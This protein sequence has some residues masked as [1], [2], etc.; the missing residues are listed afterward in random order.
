MIV[1]DPLLILVLWVAIGLVVAMAIGRASDLGERSAKE[2][3][4][5]TRPGRDTALKTPRQ[6]RTNAKR[7]AGSG[8]TNAAGTDQRESQ[9]KH[10]KRA[11]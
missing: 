11:A 7:L 8:N 2:G 4:A 3:I 5:T 10:R 9:E 1:M 6:R